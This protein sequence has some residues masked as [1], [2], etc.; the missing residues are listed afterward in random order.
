MENRLDYCCY[1]MGLSMI[2]GLPALINNNLRQESLQHTITVINSKAVIFSAEIMSGK[3]GDVL[4]KCKCFDF[5]LY[6]LLSKLIHQVADVTQFE[7]PVERLF[8]VQQYVRLKMICQP[9]WDCT[10]LTPQRWQV[11]PSCQRSL[12]HSPRRSSRRGSVD[13]MTPWS[14]STQAGPLASPRLLQLNIPGQNEYKDFS[15]G[16]QS[17]QI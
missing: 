13:T 6:Y 3:K 12:P 9:G 15:Y 17:E 4:N 14:T 1:W 10:V 2:G 8:C 5:L 11:L 16:K 7:Y